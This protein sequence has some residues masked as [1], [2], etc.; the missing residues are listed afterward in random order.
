MAVW[1]PGSGDEAEVVEKLGGGS[2]QAR[3]GGGRCGDMRL[4]RLLLLGPGS[5]GEAATSG[6]SGLMAIKTL[7]AGG[8]YGRG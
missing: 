4:V 6:N 3:R 8:G 5:T 7:M 1:Q 2:A